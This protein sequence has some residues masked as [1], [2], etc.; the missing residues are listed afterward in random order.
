MRIT[1][2]FTFG[3]GLNTPSSTVKRYSTS[4]QACVITLN[5]PYALQ[6]GAEAMRCA[7]SRCIMPVQHGMSCRLS[8]ILKKIC[9]EMS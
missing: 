9:D 8:I 3:G 2:L 4:Y 1:A 6:P 5:M 7:T